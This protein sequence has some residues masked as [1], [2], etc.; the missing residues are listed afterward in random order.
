MEIAPV[1]ILVGAGLFLLGYCLRSPMVVALFG[2]VAFGS[3]AI[4]T[5]PAAGGAVVLLYV[6]LAGLFLA[7]V[8]MQ[9]TFFSDLAR[10][11]TVHWTPALMV[12]LLAYA[13]VSALI[14]PRLFA[15]QTTVFVPLEGAIVETMLTPVSGNLRQVGYFC[16]GIMSF[17]AVSVV[18]LKHHD[19]RSI[20]VGFLTFATLIAVMGLVDLFGKVTGAGDLLEPLRTASYV[21]HVEVRVEGFWRI[22]GGHPE[23]SAFAGANL[24][25]LAFTFSYWRASGSRPVLILWS[26]LLFLLVMSTS[27]TAYVGLTVLLLIFGISWLWRLLTGGLGR[28]DVILLVVACAGGVTILGL[29]LFG[30]GRLDPAA[31]LIEATL[32]EKADS[33]SGSERLYWNQKSWLA[34]LD[35]HG[36]GVGL[37]SSRASSSFVAILSQL[38]VVG[39]LLFGLAYI[40]MVRRPVRRPPEPADA[41]LVVLC[42]ALRSAGVAKIVAGAGSSGAADPGILF[43]ITLAGLLVGRARLSE[44]AVHRNLQEDG[45][46]L[47]HQFG[48]TAWRRRIDGIADEHGPAWDGPIHQPVTG[49]PTRLSEADWAAVL[50]VFRTCLPRRGGKGKDDRTFLEAM[51]HF[52]GHGVSWRTLPKEF[53]NWNTIWKRYWRLSRSGVLKLFLDRLSATG[54]TA[55]LAPAFELGA[56][57][58]EVS[59]VKHGAPNGRAKPSIR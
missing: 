36:L 31:R 15:G 37:G 17:F 43:F 32:L 59:P 22:V 38:G 21:L 1:A 28:H 20:K 49:A 39:A 41:E 52:A 46:Y 11:F 7:F 51:R 5:L 47:P 14:F 23:A 29:V 12:L 16:V 2:S 54:R 3:T 33:A 30:D 58:G 55:H 42:Q 34:F 26:V 44:S 8:M 4:A 19:F 35:T 24:V 56:I 45:R 10:V 48:Q 53:G 50:A 18:L 40:D 9:R 6:P 57:R 27:T 25:A 13:V